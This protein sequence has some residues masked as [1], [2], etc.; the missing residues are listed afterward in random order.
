MISQPS[1]STYQPAFNAT[2]TRGPF[3]VSQPRIPDQPTS[4]EGHHVDH[5]NP[6]DFPP[7]LAPNDAMPS[8]KTPDIKVAFD[9]PI[10][11]S[12]ATHASAS[13][14]TSSGDPKTTAT[15]RVSIADIVEGPANT[16]Y[17]TDCR[18]HLKRKAPDYDTP[19]T[20]PDVASYQPDF[21]DDHLALHT[22][23]PDAQPQELVQAPSSQLTS[24]TTISQPG[25]SV[26]EPTETIEE[27]PPR[28]RT[29][30]APPSPGDNL[31]RYVATAL[32]GAVIGGVGAIAAL[33]SL[34]PDFFA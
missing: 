13:P 3:S 32:A 27:Q 9:P 10:I 6:I 5:H 2:Y 33:L 26:S 30:T 16:T 7:P 15:T 11:G 23:F 4:A 24:L 1:Y 20:N 34:P 14:V 8:N 17:S 19:T 28:K 12:Q 29:K 31:T 18:N 21:L 25:T 22:M